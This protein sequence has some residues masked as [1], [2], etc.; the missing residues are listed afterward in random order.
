MLNSVLADTWS[1]SPSVCKL[2]YKLCCIQYAIL[3]NATAFPPSLQALVLMI[4]TVI[5]KVCRSVTCWR[6]T[7]SN[8]Q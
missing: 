3:N 5:Q 6:F 7:K 2:H 8:E 1:G 4:A